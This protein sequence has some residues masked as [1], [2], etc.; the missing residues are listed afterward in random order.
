MLIRKILKA[1]SSYRREAG[2]C[3][4]LWRPVFSHVLLGFPYL[5][6]QKQLETMLFVVS[7]TAAR[8][9]TTIKLCFAKAVIW[10][11]IN[12]VTASKTFLMVIGSA[13]AVC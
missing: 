5:V 10:L 7:V 2:S 9:W 11:C 8:A 3:K 4:S 6:T 13:I 12:R 1:L